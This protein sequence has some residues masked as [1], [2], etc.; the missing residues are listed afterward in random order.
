MLFLAAVGEREY[1]CIAVEKQVETLRLVRSL[2]ATHCSHET[3]ICSPELVALYLADN[4]Q[5]YF[6]GVAPIREPPQSLRRSRRR[7]TD[8]VAVRCSHRV[9]CA[10]G[11]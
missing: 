2:R 7:R 8:I 10:A 4:L 6:V 1:C 5:V 11:E 9:V 3:N